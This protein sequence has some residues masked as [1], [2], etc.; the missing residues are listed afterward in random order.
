MSVGQGQVRLPHGHHNR[1]CTH[2]RK[3]IQ[4]YTLVLLEEDAMGS[5]A[6]QN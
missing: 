5:K 2:L 3:D 4:A 1:G 6:S